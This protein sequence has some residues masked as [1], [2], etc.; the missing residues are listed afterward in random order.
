MVEMTI[1]LV[2]TFFLII[3]LIGFIF[4]ATKK[5]KPRVPQYQANMS[6]DKQNNNQWNHID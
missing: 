6:S 1:A 5:I 2:A 4:Y 3:I